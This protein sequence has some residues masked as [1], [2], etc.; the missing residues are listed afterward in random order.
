MDQSYL[1]NRTISKCNFLETVCHIISEM[2]TAFISTDPTILKGKP[3]D[4][5]SRILSI[6]CNTESDIILYPSISALLS[7]CS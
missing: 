2:V 4:K 7:E 5:F 3:K 1:T 6:I